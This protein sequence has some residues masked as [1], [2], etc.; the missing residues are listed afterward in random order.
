MSLAKT[1]RD[2]NIAATSV[3]G[4]A[5]ATCLAACGLRIAAMAFPAKGALDTAATIAEASCTGIGVAAGAADL[6]GVIALT[7]EGVTYSEWWSAG[8]TFSGSSVGAQGSGMST[9]SGT[10]IV[11]KQVAKVVAKKTASETTKFVAKFS[12]QISGPAGGI[13]ACISAGFF[14]AAAAIKSANIAL[15]EENRKKECNK[16]EDMQGIG[17]GFLILPEDDYNHVDGPSQIAA[18]EGGMGAQGGNS[19]GGTPGAPNIGSIVGDNENNFPSGIMSSATAGGDMG[20]LLDQMPNKGKIPEALKEM[21]TSLTALA[22]QFASQPAGA[23]IAGAVPNLPSEMVDQLKD[24]DR[25][26]REGKIKF[27]PNSLFGG[28]SSGG[29]GGGSQSEAKSSPFGSLF[30]TLGT[31][32]GSKAEEV[33]FNKTKPAER[34]LAG[35]G[36][37]WHSSWNGSIFQIISIKLGHNHER[38]DSLEWSTPLNRA[39]T[40]LPKQSN[41]GGKVK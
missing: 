34:N 7:V 25:L 1:A 24:L 40:G 2:W 5:A 3:Y 4:A 12:Q 16:V 35:D 8:L 39:L 11:A 36:D 38:I 31:I 26:A 13:T 33:S 29:G 6:A 37:I 32:G 30:K 22:K 28:Y 9:G 18:G 14:A 23:V 41:Q 17:K 10:A 27:D 19:L 20:K 15:N 21:G